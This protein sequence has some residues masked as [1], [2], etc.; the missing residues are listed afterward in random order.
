MSHVL[1]TGCSSEL[2]LIFIAI[3]I[4]YVHVHVYY[5]SALRISCALEGVFPTKLIILFPSTTNIGGSTE[6]LIT[7][8]DVHQNNCIFMSNRLV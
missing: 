3:V 5:L 6:L 2:G 7:L 4:Q 1:V 8:I